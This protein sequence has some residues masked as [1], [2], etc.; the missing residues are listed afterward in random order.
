MKRF[1]FVLLALLLAAPAAWSREVYDI[2][3]GWKFYTVDRRDSAWVDLPHTWNTADA[4]VGRRDYYRGAG[5]Y[6]R[7]L[8]APAA[9]R[10]K[11]VFIRFYGAGTVADLMVNGRHAGEHRGG[12]NAFE[13]EITRL[14]DYGGKNLLWV[15]VNN[16]V[17]LDVLPTAGED[18]VYGG[19]FREVEIVVTEP[20]AIGFDGYGG[21]GVRFTAERVDSLCAS[22]V[23]SVAVNIPE[24]RPVLLDLSIRDARDSVVFAGHSKYRAPTGVS[25]AE[26][27]FEVERPHLWQGTEDPYLYTV[28][29]ALADGPRTDSVTFRTGLRAFS[30]DAVQGFFLNGK[31][32]PLRGVV[33]WRDRAGS[34]PVCGVREL[35][36]D[37]E[38]I[39]EMGANAV[40]V[41]GGTH[42]PAFYDLCDEEGI[43]VLADGPFAGVAT[44]DE[45][46]YF[47]TPEFRRNAAQQFRELVHQRYNHPSVLFWGIFAEPKLLGD[48]PIPFIREMNG[49][50]KLLDPVRLTVGV[51][52]QDG[53]VNRITDLVVWNHAFGWKT[54]MPAD[55]A[56]WRDQLHRDPV[57]NTV[58]SAV[59]YRAGGEAGQYAAQLSRPD[60]VRGRHPENWQAYVHEVHLAALARDGAFWGVFVGDMF[61]HGSARVQ[62]A[63]LRGVSDCGLVTY[64]RQVR[65]DAYWLYK[66]NWNAT[67]P[68]LHIVSARDGVRCDSVQTV[69]VYTNL[70]VAE[71]YLDGV[72]L[73]TRTA[74]D[75]VM[76][77][78]GVTLRPGDNPLRVCSIVARDDDYLTVE[79]AAVLTFRPEGRL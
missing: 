60:P 66:A 49:I 35:R 41:A 55:I 44:L 29:V 75:G 51:S 25:V 73:G 67:E 54:G 53:E 17:R 68:F 11:R 27:P 37:V 63:T 58:R 10:G 13:F 39:R 33:V 46:G 19:L 79:D 24:G 69:T 4:A 70:S 50:V 3:R 36:R 42:H 18:N 62:P 56:I 64:D 71:L 5:N 7:Y 23:A 26:L 38:L 2:G 52:S 45:R 61:D 32:Y 78:E 12:N 30:A 48:D 21:C 34:G 16:A 43:V 22:G 74:G 1:F 28:T 76:R 40:R 20:A 57:W 59:S 65:K 31:R 72:S 8:E 6:F 47:A 15:V 77:W 9:W 14:L